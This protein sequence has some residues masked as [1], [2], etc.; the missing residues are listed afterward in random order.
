[1]ASSERQN[2]N[3]RKFSE[4]KTFSKVFNKSRMKSDF[5]EKIPKFQKK[6]VCSRQG[7]PTRAM[8]KVIGP[9]ES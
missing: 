3:F 2:L 8:T 7:G 5:L 4:K 1:M 6:K 9:R